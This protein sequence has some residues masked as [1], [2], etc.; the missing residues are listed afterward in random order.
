MDWLG[1]QLLQYQPKDMV[2]QKTLDQNGPGLFFIIN[3]FYG[4]PPPPTS[5]PGTPVASDKPLKT[6]LMMA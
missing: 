6:N 3:K 5:S 2:I 1:I 4:V